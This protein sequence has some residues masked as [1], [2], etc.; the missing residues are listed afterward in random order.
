MPYGSIAFISLATQLAD[1]RRRLAEITASVRAAGAHL[2]A[3]TEDMIPLYTL[4]T[5]APFLLGQ[6]S[7]L[8]RLLPAIGNLII[9]DQSG[10]EQPL[11]H[12]GARMEACYPLFPLTQKSALSI[13]CLHYADHL[14]IGL[15]GAQEA[16]PHLQRLA[17][18]MQ[19]ALSDLEELL[20]EG[21]T[22]E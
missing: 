18:Y 19:V 15:A 2:N 5:A 8:D 3:V 1:P 6:L 14:N 4:T 7:G 20:A 13:T 11:Y 9:A 22:H 17:V 16:L 10:P 12:N 21:Q